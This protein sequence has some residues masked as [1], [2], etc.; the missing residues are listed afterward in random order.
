M[1]ALFQNR[2]KY[3]GIIKRE[4]PLQ[5]I[6]CALKVFCLGKLNIRYRNSLTGKG[7]IPT[8]IVYSLTWEGEYKH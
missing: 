8:Q 2:G 6:L 7:Q 5:A 1:V 4:K 3:S